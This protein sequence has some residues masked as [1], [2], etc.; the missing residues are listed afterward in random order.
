MLTYAPNVS[1]LLPELPFRERVRAIAEAGFDA[2][3]FGF[4][5]HTDL[6]ALEAA[7]GEHGLQVVLFNQDVP[8][9]DAANRGYL[10][11]PAR[12]SEFRRTLDQALEIARRLQALKVM[13][14]AGVELPD[15]PRA[16]QRDCLIENLRAAAPLAVQAGVLL[17]LE[18]LNPT[19]NP[20]YFVTS[21]REGFEIV[22]EV[23]HP[24]VKFQ[25]D[26]Y[27]L[28]LMEGNLKASLV[29]NIGA[30]GHI[31]FAD[32]PGRHEPG[33]G[34]VDFGELLSAAE[35]AGYHGH[36]GLEYKPLAP[37]LAALDWVPAGRR[38]Q[39]PGARRRVR[40]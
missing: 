9:W 32:T 13:L 6:P 26:T 35:A 31:Q 20:G 29:E 7:R 15:V 21:S 34:Q 33:T 12:R 25:F 36:I 19:D 2:L 17:T 1:W 16:A 8:V 38:S 14:P 18:A 3:E 37:G 11:D 5:S 22:R 28:Q 4:P 27:H 23:D 40:V 30:I 39:G 24:Q 10:A